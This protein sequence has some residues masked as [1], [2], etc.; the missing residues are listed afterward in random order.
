MNISKVNSINYN[1]YNTAFQAKTGSA[2]NYKKYI[3][4]MALPVSAMLVSLSAMAM[5]PAQ[6]AE[7]AEN[8]YSTEMLTETPQTKYY[9]T[10][11]SREQ[12]IFK[13]AFNYQ[14]KEYTLVFQAWNQEKSATA[15]QYVL[16]MPSDLD[17]K[18]KPEN[19]EYMVKELIIHKIGNDNWVEARGSSNYVPEKNAYYYKSMKLPDNLA[20]ELV[21]LIADDSRFINK[22]HIT[23]SFTSSNSMKPPEYVKAKSTLY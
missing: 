13:K 11:L 5:K 9:K 20:Q 6:P 22:T 3:S 2:K 15:V 21:D 1:A 19:G 16:I 12:Y 4:K 7:K 8:T 14:G 17:P 10:K 18:M 23:Y